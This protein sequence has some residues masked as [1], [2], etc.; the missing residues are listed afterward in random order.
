MQYSVLFLL[1]LDTRAAAFTAPTLR[2]ALVRQF[3]AISPVMQ[4]KLP[5]GWVKVKSHSHPGEL[6]Y[7]NIESG[8]IFDSLP[9]I[10]RTTW[11]GQFFDNGG[12]EPSSAGGMACDDELTVTAVPQ[13]N[14]RLATHDG[15]TWHVAWTSSAGYTPE[16]ETIPA[17]GELRVL[18]E[19][20]E[21]IVVE[22]PAFQPTSN[23]RTIKDSVHSRIEDLLR[24]PADE[25][26]D[27][28]AAGMR[29]IHLPHRLDWETSGLLVI[30]RTA[31]AM[32]SLSHQFAT[33]QVHKAYVADVLG[34]PPA[35]R[36]TCCLP[37]SADPKRRP[38]QRI[39]FGTSGKASTTRWAV[40]E[41]VE[42]LRCCRLRLEPESG[43]RHQLRMHCLALGCAMVGD[44]LYQEELTNGQQQKETQKMEQRQRLHLHAA[45]LGFTHPANG[46]AMRFTSE[47]PFT[48]ASAQE[49]TAGQKLFA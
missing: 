17:Q 18:Y 7:K 29:S 31:A 39:D 48:L 3:H 25:A 10:P 23:T 12:D 27:D 21:I 8:N 9:G 6:S 33:R 4:E 5:K 15:T 20:A 19:D 43:R 35:R 38:R 28:G 13:N 45:E 34:S 47:P 44:G 49:F 36:G 42:G 40:Q 14:S 24:L 32:R 26:L 16:P 30:A 41:R 1:G 2:S 11:K 37:L 22:K 46:E